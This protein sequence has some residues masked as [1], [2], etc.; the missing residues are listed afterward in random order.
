MYFWHA[1][2]RT[3]MSRF[4]HG[5]TAP[6]FLYRF[7]FESE[8]LINPYRFLRWGKGV[9]G[10]SHTDELSY[11]FSNCVGR[12][13]SKESR[14]YRMIERMI[15]I[16]TTFAETGNP[17]SADIE[18]LGDTVWEPLKKDEKDYK[19][20]N[21]SDELRYMELPEMEKMKAWDTLYDNHPELLC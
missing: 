8:N 15:G 10:V 18:G 11:L 5:S 4:K 19:C 6:M 1:L 21:I 16:W 12:R 7:D 3:V 9:R 13:M 17:N 14:E 20:L 2:H